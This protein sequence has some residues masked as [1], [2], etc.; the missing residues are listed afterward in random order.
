[1][2]KKKQILHSLNTILNI[3]NRKV[4]AFD[5]RWAHFQVFTV[6][7]NN[8]GDNCFRERQPGIDDLANN[9]QCDPSLNFY[10]ILHDNLTSASYHVNHHQSVQQII[11]I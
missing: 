3:T 10:K 4:G 8:P 9:V 2:I 11:G 6:L 5:V 1:M 7:F